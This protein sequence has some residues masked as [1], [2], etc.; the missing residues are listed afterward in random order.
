[1]KIQFIVSPDG[2]INTRFEG[3]TGDVCMTE[4][5]KIAK[6]LAGLGVT[7]D[8]ESFARTT[9]V[10]AAPPDLRERHRG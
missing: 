9:P 7:L 8:A 10:D 4:A 6:A 2:S 3:F 1:V 5:A